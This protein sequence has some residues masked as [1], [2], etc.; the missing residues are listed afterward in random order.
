[1][2]FN[3]LQVKQ[4][5]LRQYKELYD[6]LSKK[7]YPFQKYSVVKS[8]CNLFYALR[9]C[10]FTRHYAVIQDGIPIVFASFRFFLFNKARYVI[11]V[12]ECFDIVDLVYDDIDE[13]TQKKA[14]MILIRKIKSGGEH[15]F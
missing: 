15:M 13:N 7:C 5:Q 14:V 8:A 1:M 2:S 9:F 10:S 4:I 11:G 3:D 6:R 12:K